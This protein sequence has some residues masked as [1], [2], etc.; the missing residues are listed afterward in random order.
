M[1]SEPL[2]ESMPRMG[3][4]ITAVMS[5]RAAMT[6]LRALVGTLRFSVQPVATS[7]TV[8]VQTCSPGVPA[9]M[10]DPVDLDENRARVAPAPAPAVMADQV[11]LDETRHR[12]VPV[13]P[14]AQR[15]LTL[16]HGAGLGA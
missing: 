6:H 13:G 4:G 7:V 15:D 9:V 5:S 1:N 2:S 8:R 12:V 14:R 16:E 3:K 11:D 10:A